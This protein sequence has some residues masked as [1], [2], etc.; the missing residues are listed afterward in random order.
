MTASLASLKR[1]IAIVQKALTSNPGD[2]WRKNSDYIQSLLRCN[3]ALIEYSKAVPSDANGNGD[4]SDPAAL[5]AHKELEAAFEYHT[6]FNDGIFS[7]DAQLK[8]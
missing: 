2:D 7:I 5:A 6:K 1:E 3:D 4:F 8:L